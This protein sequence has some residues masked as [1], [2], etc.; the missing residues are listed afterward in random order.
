[1]V[2]PPYTLPLIPY[3]FKAPFLTF[4]TIMLQA[5][6][7]QLS[8]IVNPPTGKKFLLAVSGGLDSIV[9]AELF[10]LSG[11]SYSIAHCNFQLR[12]KESDEDENFVKELAVKSGVPFYSIRF[13]TEKFCLE[14]K[15]SIQMGARQLRYEWLEKTRNDNG[16][17]YLVTAHQKDDILETF[18]INLLRGTGISGLHG[19]P[20]KNGN[21]I[22][23]LLHFYRKEITDFAKE[24]NLAWREDSSNESDKYERN[25]IR[26]H[27]VPMLEEMNPKAKESISATIENIGRTELIL[28]NS[29]DALTS[30]FISKKDNR[31]L[32]HF[33]FFK[34]LNHPSVYLYE[35]IKSF[36]YNYEQCLQITDSI[37]G[38]PGKCFLSDTHRVIIDRENLIITPIIGINETS[39][40]EVT[41]ELEEII[42][43]SHVYSF[44]TH[45]NTLGNKIPVEP[46][47]ATLDFDKLTFPLKIRKWE[48]GDK[49][50]P[51]GMNKPKKVSD[52]LID[53]KVSVPDKEQVYV[54]VSGN[55]IAWL[56]GYRPDER[57]KV[58]EATKNLYLCILQKAISL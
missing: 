58:T 36:G 7:K 53:T 39:T 23:P 54:L 34:K 44:K 4:V 5:F 46:E 45:K 31:I 56:I 20:A 11:Y 21:I 50:Y 41:K 19:I 14:N 17:D 33:D 52:F 22:R 40:Y 18:F 49:F 12:G 16:L 25:K 26:H 32:I 9:I 55:D 10:R 30:G 38:Q 24:N 51:L 48:H 3:S 1:M 27:L 35:L 43:E 8:E 2:S 47:A 29:L 28:N 42:T 15:L 57:F 13:D 6:Q 37:N